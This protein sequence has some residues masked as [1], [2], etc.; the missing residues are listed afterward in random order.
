MVLMKIQDE[1]TDIDKWIGIKGYATNF[2]GIG[3]KI[4]KNNAD[5]LVDEVLEPK[6]LES[7]TKTQDSN[8]KY[9][10][11]ILKKDGIDTIHAI[12]QIQKSIGQR[13]SYLGLKDKYASTNQYISLRRMQHN[14]PLEIKLSNQVTLNLIGFYSNILTRKYLFGNHFKIRIREIEKKSLEE[15]KKEFAKVIEEKQILN[16]FGYQ[17]FGTTR[18]VNHLVGR[19][20]LDGSFEEAVMIFLTYTT[21]HQSKEIQEIRKEMIDPSNY[22]SLLNRMGPN[23]DIEK[24]IIKS[25]IERPK[26]WVRALRRIPIQIRRIFIN[27]YQSYIFNRTISKAIEEKEDISKVQVGDIYNINDNQSNQTINMRRCIETINQDESLSSTPLVQI[28][29]YTFRCREGRFENIIKKILDEEEITEK[30]FYVKQ[31]PEL[32]MEGGFRIPFLKVD[33]FSLIE[34]QDESSCLLEFTL[35]KGSYATVILRELM[36]P[37]DITV[38]G[39]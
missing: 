28:V 31:M 19:K 22:K 4:K 23:L 17:R 21:K 3:G 16:F 39:Y 20:I 26:E 13:I 2:K 8:N 24:E 7:L 33:K 10:I 35:R 37:V 9:A 27:S 1:I 18:P 6:V 29:G 25:L 36:K 32:S 34:Q 30:Q 14:A 15:E 38:A 5:F 12:Q 11:Y